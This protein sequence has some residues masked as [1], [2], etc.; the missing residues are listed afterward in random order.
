MKKKGR[1]TTVLLAA[2]F[3]V[4]LGLLLYPSVSDYWNSFHQSQVVDTYK[5]D[6]QTMDEATYEAILNE[7][8][9]YNAELAKR[10]PDAML[11]DEQQRYNRALD[12]SGTGVMGYIE[13]PSIDVSLPIFH[14]TSHE[15]LQSSVGHIEWSSLPVGGPDAHSVLSGHR[16]LPSSR[17][18]SDLDKLVVGDT[19][20]VHV[21]R[22]VYTYEVD[23]IR[24]VLPTETDSL[25]IMPGQDLC[26]L[27]TCT[28][29]GI[30]T[31][32]LLVRGH[33]VAND[34]AVDPDRVSADA[35]RIEPLVIAP[36]FF[37][38]LTAAALGVST[39]VNRRRR[40]PGAHAR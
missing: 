14:G 40:K 30:N 38:V 21:L 17:L 25:Q 22:E 35:V 6:V 7:A 12:V 24:I 1:L 10:G 29:Y 26:T 19:F 16:G 20:T 23:E 36:V 2:A 4:G 31:H 39:V 33:R 5:E 18:L 15:V 32:R 28:P 8:R 3:L 27:V 9:D 11:A 37:A 13:I 34:G